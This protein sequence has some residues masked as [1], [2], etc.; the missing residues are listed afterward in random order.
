MTKANCFLEFL[1]FGLY[2]TS[3][4][5][6]NEEFSYGGHDAEL[7]GTVTVQKGNNAGLEMKEVLPVGYTYYSKNEINA[8][9][10]EFGAF[11]Y[12]IDYDP[13]RK[14]CNHFTEHL[15]KFI[16]NR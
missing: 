3:V 13:F 2:H 10:E 9:V 7:P 12:G 6:Y 4:G 15:I 8:I 16:C 1:G 11:W 14:N 5:T